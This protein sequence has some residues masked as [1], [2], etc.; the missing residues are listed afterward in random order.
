MK[1]LEDIR[2]SLQSK[3]DSDE[4]CD[5]INSQLAAKINDDIEESQ[6][7]EAALDAEE[8]SNQAEIDD[9]ILAAIEDQ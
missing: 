4:H 9:K 3:M 7:L 8:T 6:L 2:V 1:G 5:D